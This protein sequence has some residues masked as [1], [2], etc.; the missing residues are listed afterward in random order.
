MSRTLEHTPLPWC[1][2]C[3]GDADYDDWRDLSIVMDRDAT[4]RVAFMANDG[5]PENRTSCANAA[6]IVR[7][8]N[9]HYEL[10][11]ALKWLL[12]GLGPGA[13]TGVRHAS[14]PSARILRAIEAL[15]RAEA[16]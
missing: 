16:R 13:Q 15:D 9:N 14:I 1:A 11:Q 8:V 2:A 7:A 12:D 4:M 5:T 10:I 3:P 6:L